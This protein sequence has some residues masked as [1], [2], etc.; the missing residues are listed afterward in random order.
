MHGASH[1]PERPA[2]R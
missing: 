2:N 1:D